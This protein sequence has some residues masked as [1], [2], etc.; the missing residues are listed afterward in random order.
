MKPTLA[1]T[2]CSVVYQRSGSQSCADIIEDIYASCSIRF[3][4]HHILCILADGVDNP[5]SYHLVKG[6]VTKID[7]YCVELQW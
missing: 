7:S 2:C 1:R 3:D 4:E 5:Y 6:L